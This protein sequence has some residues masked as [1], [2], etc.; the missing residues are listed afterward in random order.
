VRKVTQDAA[1][2]F[3]IGTLGEGLIQFNPVDDSVVHYRHDPDT[4]GSLPND[5]VI[6]IIEDRRGEL[7]IGTDGGG[8]A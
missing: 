7:W 2:L 1:G 5:H 3:W 8:L 6:D 4:T